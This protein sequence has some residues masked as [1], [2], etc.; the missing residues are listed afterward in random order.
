MTL[1]RREGGAILKENSL[2]WH[3]PAA[4]S[5]L[6]HHLVHLAF[7]A[8]HL[9]HLAKLLEERID[10]SDAGAAAAGDALAA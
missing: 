2:K 3:F 10:L 6:L 9:A 8:H 1:P 7:A 5:E 4:T